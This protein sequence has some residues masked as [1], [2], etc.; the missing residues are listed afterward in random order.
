MTPEFG[1]LYEVWDCPFCGAN[2]VSVIR[3]PKNVSIKSARIA[4]LPG[5]SGFHKNPDV[6]LVQSGCS[7]CDK[8]SDE[9]E[10]KLK[11]DGMT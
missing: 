9:V 6:Y 10:K 4:S 11:V 5:G 7:K 3:F 8:T 1:R 2:A